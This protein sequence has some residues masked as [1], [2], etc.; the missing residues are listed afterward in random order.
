[1]GATMADA[2][3]EAVR[4][5]LSLLGCSISGGNAFLRLDLDGRD[6]SEKSALEAVGDLEHLQYLSLKE[7]KLSDATAVGRIKDLV[8]LDLSGN[9]LKAMPALKIQRFLQVLKLANNNITAV[10][11]LK[12]HPYLHTL[13]LSHNKLADL[14][15]L[16]SP[17]L[18]VL[19]V[20][21]NELAAIEGLKCP[22]L[23][24][25]SASCNKIKKMGAKLPSLLSLDLS[26]NAFEA[27]ET[28]QAKSELPS[29][30]T[31]DLRKN[32][33]PAGEDFYKELKF[34]GEWWS[35]EKQPMP[36]LTTLKVADQAWMQ[37]NEEGETSFDAGKHPTEVLVY[38]PK[39]KALDDLPIQEEENEVPF[40]TDEQLEEAAAKRA[41]IEE[42]QKAEYE[43]KKAEEAAEAA[44]LKAEEDA[45]AAAEPEGEE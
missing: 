31:L 17:A 8:S 14:K 37:P 19:N 38:L 3:T 6:L 42:A 26:E 12:A 24:S 10:G 9:E 21:N 41:E 5:G 33:L 4:A 34:L 28:L 35:H 20:S 43:K 45:A 36:N 30:T 11:S 29:V 39:L 16:D 23:E 1:M 25:L 18:R 44:R 22:V 7:D 32:T 27:L 15:A 2:H 13:D 40:P